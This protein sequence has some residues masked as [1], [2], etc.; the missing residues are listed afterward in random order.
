MTEQLAVQIEWL[1]RQHRGL[2]AQVAVLMRRAH[3]TPTEQQRARELKKQRLSAK[4]RLAALRR[5]SAPPGLSSQ[6]D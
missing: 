1:E 5:L 3:L 4:D 2:D 6:T